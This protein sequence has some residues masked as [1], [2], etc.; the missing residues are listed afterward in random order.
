MSEETEFRK[1]ATSS[2]STGHEAN[3]WH[4]IRIARVGSTI[5]CFV[6]GKEVLETTDDTYSLG[7]IGL[8]VNEEMSF[9]NIALIPRQ[10]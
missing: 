8:Y 10:E 2:K 5:K 1:L 4:Q 9:R 6:N 3:V 7:S